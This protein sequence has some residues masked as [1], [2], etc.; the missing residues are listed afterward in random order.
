MPLS[1]DSRN[2]IRQKIRVTKRQQRRNLSPLKQRLNANKLA[3]KLLHL[4]QVK[5]ANK[6]AVYLSNDGEI[7]VTQLIKAL[8]KA[9]KC[10]Y[11]PVLDKKLTGHLVFLPYYKNQ[12]LIKNKYKILEPVYSYKNSLSAK[13]LDLILMPLVSFDQRGN[14]IGMGGGYYDRSL[15]Y[16][17]QSTKIRAGSKKPTLIGV[18]HSIQEVDDIPIESWD[19]KLDMIV[20][21]NK[22]YLSGNYS[23]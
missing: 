23:D 16:L 9:N 18:A 12:R 19:I 1:L 22:C 15:S 14:R 8:W 10:C 7:N 4:K 11:L 2:K 5:Q 13:H 6:I 17:Q 20:T 21:D 3:K